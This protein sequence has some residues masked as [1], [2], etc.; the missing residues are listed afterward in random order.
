MG[1]PS[2]GVIF[3]VTGGI[4]LYYKSMNSKDKHSHLKWHE[5]SREE[6]LDA[7]IFKIHKSVR[8]TED[9]KEGHFVIVDAPHWITVVPVVKNDD[10]VDCF[11]MVRQFR[12]GSSD[13]TIEFP[14]GVVEPGEDP[15]VA[16]KRELLEETGYEPA[17]L[18]HVGTINP[19]PAFMSNAFSIY[20]ATNM[21]KVE[22]QNLD[23]HEMIDVELIPI[24]EVDANMGTGYYNSAIMIV[25][26]DRYKRWKK[27]KQ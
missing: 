19:N 17:D 6:V 18:A 16:A 20:V 21:R 1:F 11:L 13:I 8:R 14:A 23:D 4:F 3:I 9:K 12:H 27:S 15:A 2:F 22:N 26:L 25:A 5:I 7:R 24:A 10:G